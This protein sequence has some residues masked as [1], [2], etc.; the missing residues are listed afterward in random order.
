MRSGSAPAEAGKGTGSANAFH[1]IA[2]RRDLR[3]LFEI[4]DIRTPVHRTASSVTSYFA[5]FNHKAR[6]V[7]VFVK[8]SA[9]ERRWVACCAGVSCSTTPV[10]AP[11]RIDQARKRV[12]A[13]ANLRQLPIILNRPKHDKFGASYLCQLHSLLPCRVSDC[14][15]ESS[16]PRTVPSLF[17]CE[18]R[19]ATDVADRWSTGENA[20]RRSDAVGGSTSRKIHGQR[21][22]SSLGQT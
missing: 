6:I 17:C 18:N 21:S 14:F 11:K 19:E 8:V 5:D 13:S 9:C 4:R 10:S 1:C 20:G 3:H 12:A 7:V 16:K 22:S 2:L 15:H